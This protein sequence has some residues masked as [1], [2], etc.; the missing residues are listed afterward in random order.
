MRTAHVVRQGV[1]DEA[2]AVIVF[3]AYWNSNAPGRID[4]QTPNR[5]NAALSVANRH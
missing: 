5:E 1:E 2:N 3:K 4:K